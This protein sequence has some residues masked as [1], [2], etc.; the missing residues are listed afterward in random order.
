MK[1]QAMPMPQGQVPQGM[2]PQM[3]AQRQAG[4]GQ[5]MPAPQGMAPP[6][7]GGLPPGI[8]PRA[9]AADPQGFARWQQG[10]AAQDQMMAARPQQPPRRMPMPVQGQQ[11]RPNPQAMQA[12]MQAQ[13]LRG[14]Q[15]QA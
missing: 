6:Q 5:A 2:P 14:L 7:G 11:A 1:N 8:D 10:K 13:A 4:K 15:G 12:M 9:V 3:M